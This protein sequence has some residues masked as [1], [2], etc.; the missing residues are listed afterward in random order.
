MIR[1]DPFVFVRNRDEVKAWIRKGKREE[2]ARLSSDED[3]GLN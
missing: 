3:A 2:I 1:S